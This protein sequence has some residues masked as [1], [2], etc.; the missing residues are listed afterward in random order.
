MDD[1]IYVAMTGAKHVEERQ[2]TVANNLANVSTAGFRAQFDVARAVPVI[3]NTLPTRA[4][5]VSATA[6]NDLTGG[7]IQHT[8]NALDVAVQGIGWIAVQA[9]DGQEA[10]TR[11]GQFKVSENGLLQTQDGLNI[12]GDG[13][14][15][16]VPPDSVLAIAADGT[17]SVV[18]TEL[19][20]GTPNTLGRI[21]LVN[22]PRE[23]LVRGLDGLFRVD[24]GQA[25]ALDETV[26]LQPEAFETS[27][28]NA[29]G[30]MVDMI[31]LSRQ[32]DM[33][34]NVIK[35][36]E[37]NDDKARQIITR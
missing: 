2:A 20:P 7:G 17:V 4:F 33:I 34:I 9:N 3:S 25:A 26:R 22:P 1:L 29:V 19:K 12:V 30:S 23:N 36:A 32:F 18:S 8:G 15:I 5:V 28:V 24:N 10:Y 6:G 16:T 11:N 31:N 13:G 21:K 27:N 37:A 35:K 14:P